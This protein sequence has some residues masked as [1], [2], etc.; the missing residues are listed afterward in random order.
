MT[1]FLLLLHEPRRPDLSLS[2]VNAFGLRFTTRFNVNSRSFFTIRSFF[3]SFGLSFLSIKA[4]FGLRS[5]SVYL[6]ANLRSMSHPRSPSHVNLFGLGFTILAFRSKHS[7]RN[8]SFGLRS[9]TGFYY[10]G[11]GL[12]LRCGVQPVFSPTSVF[13]FSHQN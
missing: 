8:A 2:Y 1:R 3:R 13:S 9:L 4:S 7:S 11:D 12:G 10:S 5:L 6:G